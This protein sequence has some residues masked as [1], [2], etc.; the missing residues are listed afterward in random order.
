MDGRFTYKPFSMIVLCSK[1]HQPRMARYR[2]RIVRPA[3]EDT[4]Y[5]HDKEHQA[6]LVAAKKVAN[7]LYNGGRVLVTCTAGLNRSGLV[8]GLALCMGTTLHGEN[9]VRL[10]RRA[11][12][13][14]ALSNR[15]FEKIVRDFAQGKDRHRV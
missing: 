12:G 14:D 3:F 10:I 5:P 6:A 7:E 11:R 9:I 4:L 2:G 13:E 8:T 15:T 1:E